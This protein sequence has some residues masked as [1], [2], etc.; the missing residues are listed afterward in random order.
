MAR[1]FVFRLEA[2]LRVRKQELDAQK[3]EVARAVL[4]KYDIEQHLADRESTLRGEF[5]SLRDE[6]ADSGRL[7][8]AGIR[9]HRL[10][11]GRLHREIAETYQQLGLKDQELA[12]EREKLAEASKRLKAIEKLKEKRWRRYITELNRKEQ[13]MDDETELQQYMRVRLTKEV[14]V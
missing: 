9:G 7:D 10:Y 11:M 12:K 4:E 5:E 2:L 13:A 14:E 3:R 8:L 1:G 6:Q